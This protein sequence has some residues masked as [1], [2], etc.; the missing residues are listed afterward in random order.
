MDWSLPSPLALRRW[1][2]LAM[3]APQAVSPHNQ[4]WMSVSLA[5]KHSGPA[6][7]VSDS[8]DGRQFVQPDRR[9]TLP[10]R[11]AV[12]AAIIAG[13][14]PKKSGEGTKGTQP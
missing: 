13:A 8:L 10:A 4:V 14:A 3:R 2:T 1:A 11:C 7:F 9:L 5:S 12:A 6:G